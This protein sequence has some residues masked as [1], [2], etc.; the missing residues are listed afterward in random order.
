MML[1]FRRVLFC[2]SLV[3]VLLVGCVA[4]RGVTI[5]G[6]RRINTII[7]IF[8]FPIFFLDFIAF[9]F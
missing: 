5:R 2:F 1:F 6:A 9:S 3:E 4:T 7:C 8:L